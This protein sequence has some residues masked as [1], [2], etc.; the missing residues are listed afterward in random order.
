MLAVRTRW[1]NSVIQC[2]GELFMVILV[3]INTAMTVR[4]L[5]LKFVLNMLVCNYCVLTKD[6]NTNSLVG[7]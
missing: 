3:A 6:T 4:S 2:H 1:K 5:A 7:Q